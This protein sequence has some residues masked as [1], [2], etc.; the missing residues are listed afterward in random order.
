MHAAVTCSGS[1]THGHTCDRPDASSR[2]RPAQA[3]VRDTHYE[4]I[5]A[6]SGL[7]CATLRYLVYKNDGNAVGKPTW[8]WLHQLTPDGTATVGQ[9]VPLI[10]NTL[11]RLTR[12]VADHADQCASLAS[13]LRAASATVQCMSLTD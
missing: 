7:T 10:R 12:Q 9:P 4:R 3:Q 11:V 6:R 1:F 2:F 8:L 13:C 5:D